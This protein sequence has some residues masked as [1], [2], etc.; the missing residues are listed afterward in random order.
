M[1]HTQVLSSLPRPGGVALSW[2]ARD[3]AT[4]EDL[5]PGILIKL[6]QNRAGDYVTAWSRDLN[7]EVLS[8]PDWQ[9]Q[10]LR[11]RQC[12]LPTLEKEEPGAG[13]SDALSRALRAAGSWCLQGA[14]DP[15]THSSLCN[16]PPPR[17]LRC[18][19]NP[20]TLFMGKEVLSPTN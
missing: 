8:L 15:V 19:G 1:A 3:F 10:D 14:K 4:W 9:C 13:R 2:L 11:G 7:L 17:S 16:L 20:S 12:Q 6:G 5:T 18:S